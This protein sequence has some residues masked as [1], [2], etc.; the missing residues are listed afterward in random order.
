MTLHL[1][2]T[3][4]T[5]LAG[6]AAASGATVLPSPSWA[7]AGAPQWIAAAGEQGETFALYGIATDGSLAFRV[8]LPGRGHA[9]A[10][11]PERAEAVAF[12]RR[13]GTFALVLD[14]VSGAVLYRLEAP[15]GRH[16]YGHGTFAE[17]GRVLVTTENA[18]EAGEGRLGLWDASAGYRRMGELASGGVGPH[19]V[20]TLP[21]GTLA[22]GNGGIR[23]HPDMGREKLN[24]AVMRPSL[25]HLRPDGTVLEKVELDPAMRMASIRHLA[26]RADGT[27]AFA[28]QWEGPG[29]EIVPLLGLHR[30]GERPKLLA[31]PDPEQGRLRGYAGSVAWSGDGAGVAITSPRG[32]VAHVFGADGS[33]LEVFA[34]ADICG[35]ASAPGGLAFSD[36]MGALHLPGGR[37]AIH[38]LAWDNHMIA[39]RD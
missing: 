39:L 7:A 23:T 35:V 34:R 25:V 11:H 21:D 36:G 24:L 19:E 17:G 1:A 18:Y 29:G 20:V 6:L 30:R 32:S 14:C 37:T 38:P 28:M 22:V 4:R 15:A 8:P 2:T 5:V 16:F 31:A 10:A 12:A 13:P 33:A 3:R 9:A 27:V 26:A